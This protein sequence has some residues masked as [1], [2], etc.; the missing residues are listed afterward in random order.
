MVQLTEK[1][2]DS[3]LDDV[4]DRLGIII[5]KSFQ[6]QKDH[7]DARIDRLELRIERI[8]TELTAVSNKLS[9]HLE[10]S[11]KRY[12]EIKRRQVILAKWVKQV[13]DKTGVEIDLAEL[14]KF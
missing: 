4:V 6:E 5:N 14:D 3:K 13:A 2:L 8:E 10:L 9:A 1:Y 11:D 12:L 7:F